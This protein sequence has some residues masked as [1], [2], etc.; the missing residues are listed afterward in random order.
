MTT[1][2][3]ANFIILPS[4]SGSTTNYC[5]YIYQ[6][7]SA[8]SISDIQNIT[9]NG[10]RTCFTIPKELVITTLVNGTI[11]ATITIP[12]QIYTVEELITLLTTSSGFEVRTGY[13]QFIASNPSQSLELQFNNSLF[14]ILSPLL[15]LLPPVTTPGTY[16]IPSDGIFPGYYMMNL[17]NNLQIQLGFGKSTLNITDFSNVSLIPLTCKIRESFQIGNGFDNPIILP[18]Y[19]NFPLASLPYLY[20]ILYLRIRISTPDYDLLPYLIYNL[21]LSI[22]FI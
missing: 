7:S 3:Q 20:Q 14:S 22:S 15:G 17:F 11:F 16:T 9:I 18:S 6:L 21:S 2:G 5:D 13:N 10:N 4:N 1:L 12:A 19:G 8:S